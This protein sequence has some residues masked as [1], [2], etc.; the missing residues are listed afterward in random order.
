MILE[1]SHQKWHIWLNDYTFNIK[2]YNLQKFARNKHTDTAS[3]MCKNG[4]DKYFS[5]CMRSK[6]IVD[7]DT[8]LI[9]LKNNAQWSNCYHVTNMST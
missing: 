2:Y 4:S 7:L 6:W 5:N 1:L 9:H 3:V 8:A